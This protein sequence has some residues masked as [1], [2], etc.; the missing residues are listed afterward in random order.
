M[1]TSATS[2]DSEFL[3]ALLA[4]NRKRCAEIVEEYRTEYPGVID[5]Y[6][7]L[8]KPALY[9]VGSLWERNLI[10]VA[11]E[12]LATALVGALL[13]DLYDQILPEAYNGRTVVASCVEGEA[14]QVGI[15]MVADVF[16]MH[17]WRSFF[18]GADVPTNELLTFAGEVEADL[19]ALSLSVYFHVPKLETMLKLLRRAFPDLPIVIGGQAFRHG[20]GELLDRYPNTAYLPDL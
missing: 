5:L 11:T 18:L 9:E 13:N 7:K 15:K 8:F 1:D 10:S 2:L 19:I 20:G 12:H 3:S 4:G 17:G 14:H 6:E 16:E